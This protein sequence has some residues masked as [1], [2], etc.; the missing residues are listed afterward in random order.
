MIYLH[1]VGIYLNDER[2]NM[3]NTQEEIDKELK[4]RELFKK[5]QAVFEYAEF[6]VKRYTKF[7][8]KHYA[9]NSISF[10]DLKQESNI[11]VW[12]LLEKIQNG[13][14]YNKDRVKLDINNAV[15]VKRF[16]GNAVGRRMNILRIFSERNSLGTVLGEKLCQCPILDRDGFKREELDGFCTT[17]GLPQGHKMETSINDGECGEELDMEQINN[18]PLEEVKAKITFE[19]MEALCLRHPQIKKNDFRMFCERHFDNK[20]LQSIG[21]KYK[22][23]RERVRQKIE[24]V[25]TL[26]K[27]YFS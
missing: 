23:S 2:R 15:E 20:T 25:S 16:I 14:V 18:F 8:H 6:I 22:V 17:C 21:T 19:E 10:E 12:Q 11:V 7:Y 26:L 24:R 9:N 4:Y 1:L 27:K 5:H 3:L 13:N